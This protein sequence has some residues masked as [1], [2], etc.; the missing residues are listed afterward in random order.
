M[1][2]YPWC[3]CVHLHPDPGFALVARIEIPAC[4]AFWVERIRIGLVTEESQAVELLHCLREVHVL[5]HLGCRRHKRRCGHIYEGAAGGPGAS[6]QPAKVPAPAKAPRS[7]SGREDERRGRISEWPLALQPSF[8]A[9]ELDYI[10]LRTRKQVKRTAATPST[11]W[12]LPSQGGDV[13][14]ESTIACVFNIFSSAINS[15]VLT[16]E[17]LE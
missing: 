5:A 12:T 1:P 10:Y 3:R 11:R 9:S 13:Q 8:A 16:P 15:S 6:A 17:H 2:D 7:S 14:S 4:P